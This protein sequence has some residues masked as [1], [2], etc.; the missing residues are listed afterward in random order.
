MTEVVK[1]PRFHSPEQPAVIPFFF[2]TEMWERFGFYTVQALLVLYMTSSVLN[3]SDAKSYG[4]L[5]AVSAMAYIMPIFGGY[6]AS[7]VLDYEHAVKLGGL[8]LIVGY[9]LLSLSNQHLFF[10]A[11]AIITIGTGFFKPNISCYLGDFY[12]KDDPYREKG[13]TIFYIGINIGALLST[14]VSGYIVRYLGW[15]TPFALASIGLIIGTAIFT[16][17]LN[18][19]KK[20]GHFHRIKNATA[21]KKPIAILFVYLSIPVQ[22]AFSYYII[23]NNHFADAVMLWGGLAVF[24]GIFFYALKYDSSQRKKL[25]VALLL[26]VISVVYWALYFQMFFSMNLFIERAVDRHLFSL[27]L[28]TPIYVAAESIFLIILGPFLALLWQKL[29]LIKKNPSTPLKF[30]L[31]MILLCASFLIVFLGIKVSDGGMNNMFFILFTYFLIAVTELLLSPIG[32]SM[33]TVLSP[34]ELVGLMMGVWF[35]SLGLGEKLAGVIAN[36]AAIPKHIV[37]VS[38][39]DAIYADAFLRYAII[40]LICAVIVL[41]AVPFLNRMTR[42]HS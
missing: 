35:V 34:H 16:F 32:L 40:S 5:G 30:A 20:T 2:L 29:S 6:L 25:H 42:V 18:H 3:F 41:I 10:L 12:H 11:L 26:T 15:R 27:K 9:A 36:Y 37:L 38:S 19:L 7:K 23:I 21:N 31:A 33:I 4:I 24:F 1:N 39:M 22:I 13:Y 8:L 14:S 17:G 28:P